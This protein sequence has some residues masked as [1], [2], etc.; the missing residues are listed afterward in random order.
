MK[1]F[2]FGQPDLAKFCPPEFNIKNGCNTIKLGTLYDYR[3]IENEKL[4]DAGEGTF[5][6]GIKFPKLT[7]VSPEWIG[8]FEV[9]SDGSAHI[10]E[11]SISN[12]DIFIKGVTLSGSSHN[13][14]VFCVSKSSESAGNVSQTH[15]DKWLIPN[16]KIDSLRDY[17]AGLLWSS[18]TLKDVPA[19]IIEN[20]SIQEIGQHL[21]LYAQVR[22][23]DYAERLL[24]IESEA[25]LPIDQ[26]PYFRDSIPF[27]KPKIFEHE[28]ELRFIFWLTFKQQKISIENNTKILKLRVIDSIV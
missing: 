8:A 15:E 27:I 28:Q 3:T 14:W 12:G 7:R 6:Y 16:E 9:D 10:E 25:D 20:H 19:Y 23:I 22:E 17:L 4:R 26:I 5:T 1:L 24:N 11:M 2:G 21:G 18:V 13:C